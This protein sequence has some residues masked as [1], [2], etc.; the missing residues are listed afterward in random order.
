LFAGGRVF[1]EKPKMKTKPFWAPCWLAASATG[2]E[3]AVTLDWTNSGTTDHGTN[4]TLYFPI[5][6][7]GNYSLDSTENG[8]ATMP[9]SVSGATGLATLDSKAFS[10]A[11]SSVNGQEFKRQS[12]QTVADSNGNWRVELDPEATAVP[13][14]QQLPKK[15]G[16]RTTM[17]IVFAIALV[18]TQLKWPCDTPVYPYLSI[19][20]SVLLGFDAMLNG[21]QSESAIFWMRVC[22]SGIPAIAIVVVIGLA[23]PI[24]EQ[25]AY[26]M[27]SL[28]EERRK[29]NVNI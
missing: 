20:P 10:P 17:I 24:T 19:I 27:K 6:S 9:F 15:I 8:P 7:A 11:F 12:K 28:L 14:L 3:A 22:F 18:G 21:S 25:K 5:A 23:Y 2:P 29:Q 4:F 26:G 13:L 1:L 16:K